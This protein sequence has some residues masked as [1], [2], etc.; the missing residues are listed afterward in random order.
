MPYAGMPPDL[1][2][3]APCPP[4]VC[5]APAPQPGDGCRRSCPL[6]GPAAGCSGAGPARGPAAGARPIPVSRIHCKAGREPCFPRCKED[7]LRATIKS[8]C[9]ALHIRCLCRTQPEACAACRHGSHGRHI[10]MKA[11]YLFR[12]PAAVRSALTGAF[13]QLRPRKM[14]HMHMLQRQI[15]WIPQKQ[16][17]FFKDFIQTRYL[18]V[19]AWPLC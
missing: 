12:N 4:D 11:G 7:P 13:G 19:R 18:R 1:I 10:P 3:R 14:R 5:P 2:L 8:V 15:L 9:R 16:S 17:C 6:P